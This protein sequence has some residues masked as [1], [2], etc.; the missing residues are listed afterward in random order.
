ME[1]KYKFTIF[2]PCYNSEKF[3]HRVFESLAN[4]T[5]KNFEWIVIND[6]STD[7]TGQLIKDF[8]A[9]ADFD[10]QFFNLEK[11]QMLTKNYNLAVKNAQGEFFM[12]L[13]HDDALVNSALQTFLN[14]YEKIPDDKKDSYA[15][16]S[17]TCVDQFGKLIG[18]AYPESPY[19]S[20]FYHTVYD[21]N[22]EGEKQGFVKTKIMREFPI[23]ELD[24][25]V[26][27]GLIWHHVGE[28]YNTLFVNDS[29]RIYYI[30][31]THESL[32]SSASKKI[33]YPKGIRF[34]TLC[35]LNRFFKKVKKNYLLKFKT[36]IK[37]GRMSFHLKIYLIK[38]AG[39]IQSPVYKVAYLFLYPAIVLISFRDKYL[40]NI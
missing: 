19:L 34:Y 33:R 25:Y 8:I 15:G 13:G 7:N 6:N 26:P 11:N 10:V 39:E 37:Y 3:I 32:S 30:N 21:L 24:I 1:Y 23:P 16:V 27:E 20:N 9:T 29:L 38:S 17:C 4:Q 5:Y 31:Q 12:P 14:Y 22:I 40:K 18:D 28:K 2:T 35:Q 36:L